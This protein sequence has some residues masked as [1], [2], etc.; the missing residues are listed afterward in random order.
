MHCSYY[1]YY[2]ELELKLF[3]SGGVELHA[4]D[5]NIVKLKK[6]IRIGT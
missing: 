5:I 2:C 1:S 3:L 6:E 4:V